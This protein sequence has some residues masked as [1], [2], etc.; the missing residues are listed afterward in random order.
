[1]FS[2]LKLFS[3]PWK[4]LYW[5]QFAWSTVSIAARLS[6]FRSKYIIFCL[7][8]TDE[9]Y[10]RRKKI[11]RNSN[12]TEKLKKIRNRVNKNT[13]PKNRI[14]RIIL[15]LNPLKMFFSKKF[16]HQDSHSKPNSQFPKIELLFSV[17]LILICTNFFFGC[18]KLICFVFVRLL[19]V[20]VSV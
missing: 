13:N 12:R 3:L 2:T 18:K 14:Y 9:S 1:M 8:D 20:T 10:H 16:N 5:S 7:V 15:S 19:T 11:A 6:L 17:H 4:Y